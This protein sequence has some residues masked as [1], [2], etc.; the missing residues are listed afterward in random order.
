MAAQSNNPVVSLTDVF[1]TYKVGE[2]DVPA[3][4]GVTFNIPRRRF[5]VI[6]GPSG[7]GKTT[8]LNLIGC[9][10][11]PTTGRVIVAGQDLATLADNV[12][13]DFRAQNVGFI[14]QNFSLVP[15]FSAY[16]NIEYP[17]LLL[18]VSAVERRRRATHMLEAVGLACPGRPPGSAGEAVDV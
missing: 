4:K 8:L 2:V 1:K 13:S 14:F 3:V 16:E 11:K 5:S 6:V 18:G 7:S 17:L 12:I 15:V 9:L 10:D